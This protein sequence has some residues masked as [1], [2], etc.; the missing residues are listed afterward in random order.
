MT[1]SIHDILES[2]IKKVKSGEREVEY[3]TPDQLLKAQLDLED[4][5]AVMTV[6]THFTD[7]YQ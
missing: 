6:Q 1:R 7:G 2:G 3:F 5:P 4:K